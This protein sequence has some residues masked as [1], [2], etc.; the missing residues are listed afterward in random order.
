MS[1]AVGGAAAWGEDTSDVCSGFAAVCVAPKSPP[2]TSPLLRLLQ[3]SLSPLVS[4]PQAAHGRLSSWR[5]VVLAEGRW[6]LRTSLSR[7][8]RRHGSEGRAVSTVGSDGERPSTKST[9]RSARV[10][11]QSPRGALSGRRGLAPARLRSASSAAG[12]G[13]E[14][15]P[16]A[17]TQRRRRPRSLF[18]RQG[19][20][21]ETIPVIAVAE[22]PCLFER[23]GG[24]PET[25]PV[26]S[27][28][29]DTVCP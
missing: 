23:Q 6:S 12:E 22:T 19:D 26:T 3:N 7:E 27:D 16:V 20:V 8:R 9:L 24:V 21:P 2:A 17:S 13:V 25:M 11:T 5:P 4:S 1:F 28:S 29:G 18:E 15:S 10:P 14:C